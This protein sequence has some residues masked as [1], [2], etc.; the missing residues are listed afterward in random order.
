MDIFKK[1]FEDKL[2]DRSK[3][4]SSLKDKCIS[5]KDHFIST[6]IWK[7]FKMNIMG[8]YHDVCSKTDVLLLAHLF[9]KFINTSLDYYLKLLKDIVKQTINTG[10]LMRVVKKINILCIWMQI[11]IWLVTE[12]IFALQ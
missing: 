10:N 8:D 7:K 5:K 4:L 9:E 3:F 2:P 6:D 11:F 1:F 12:S